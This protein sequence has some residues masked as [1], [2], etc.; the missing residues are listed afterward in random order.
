MEW[1][2]TDDWANVDLEPVLANAAHVAL[3][4]IRTRGSDLTLSCLCC[5]VH[6]YRSRGFD[7][8]RR[9]PSLRHERVPVEQAD[10]AVVA[11]DFERSLERRGMTEGDLD[12]VGVHERCEPSARVASVRRR[13]RTS[14]TVWQHDLHRWGH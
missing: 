1:L 9:R 3:T 4:E 14:K 2:P 5:V 10:C 12:L 7:V 8:D 11:F 13:E 6:G